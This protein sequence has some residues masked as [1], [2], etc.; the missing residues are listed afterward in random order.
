MNSSLSWIGL[1]VAL[2][3]AAVVFAVG[4]SCYQPVAPN[5]NVSMPS[6]NLGY[7]DAC[8]VSV[9][10]PELEIKLVD[11]VKPNNGCEC[12]YWFSVR[13]KTANV[14]TK[15]YKV[16]IQP[17]LKENASSGGNSAEIRHLYGKN[18]MPQI[19]YPDV[20]NEVR[21]SVAGPCPECFS[22]QAGPYAYSGQ[23]IFLMQ[24]FDCSRVRTYRV[25]YNLASQDVAIKLTNTAQSNACP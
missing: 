24:Y 3:A 19:Y 7:K 15:A 13:N 12:Q 21:F 10:H 14:G 16:S 4:I 23:I 5:N 20:Q 6:V 1:T 8:V 17:I 18:A 9:T 2:L 22:Y 11:I 25:Q